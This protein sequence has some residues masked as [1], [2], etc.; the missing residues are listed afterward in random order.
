MKFYLGS[1]GDVIYVNE[2]GNI[3]NYKQAISLIY[4]KFTHAEFFLEEIK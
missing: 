3:F 1:N 4:F 2:R